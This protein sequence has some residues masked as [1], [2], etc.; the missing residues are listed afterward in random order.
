MQLRNIIAIS[1]GEHDLEKRVDQ[2]KRSAESERVMAPGD[3]FFQFDAFRLDAGERVLLRNG[4]LVHLPAKVFS[5]LL[6]LV[7]NNGHVVEKD[8]LMNEVWPDEFVEE[9]NLAQH[10]FILRRAL[11]E[12]SENPKYIETVPRRGYRFVAKM[13]EPRGR[14]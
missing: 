1:L 11:G 4:R 7:R 8:V 13:V 9:G 14:G 10:I 2:S 6:V 3:N 5:T 12:S